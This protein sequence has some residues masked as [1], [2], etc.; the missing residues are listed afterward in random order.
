[1]RSSSLLCFMAMSLWMAT[2]WA[3]E[4][5]PKSAPIPGGIV[6]LPLNTAEPLEVIFAGHRV[7]TITHSQN[8][9]LVGI[10]LA[11]K[12]GIYN[13]LIHETQAHTSQLS[14]SIKPHRY[15]SQYL[16]IKNTRLVSPAPQDVKR[17][18]KEQAFINRLKTTWTARQAPDMQFAWPVQGRISSSFG[19]QRFYNRQPRAPH[20]GLDIAAPLNTP[21]KAPANATVLATGNFLFSGNTVYLDHGQGL[22]S[23]YGHLNSIAVQPGQEVKRGQLLGRVGQTGRATGPHLHWAVILNTAFIDPAL[24]LS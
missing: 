15:L 13:I 5:L 20:A 2:S 18:V 17:I 24:F 19:L 4:P 7:M 12:P 14:F 8:Y 9:A 11:T 16:Q 21:V 6:I 22:L 10:P 23:M 1:M 3:T